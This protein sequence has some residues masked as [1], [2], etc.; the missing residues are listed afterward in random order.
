MIA[1]LST[2]KTTPENFVELLKTDEESFPIHKSVKG[3]V[4][5]KFFTD[6]EK[7]MFAYVSVWE[8]RK[9]LDDY[10][11]ARDKIYP[12][13][14]EKARELVAEPPFAHIYEV[15]EPKTE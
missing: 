5:V 6:V 8:T 15:Y 14:R 2:Y 3:C 4:D 11:E 1:V 7:N 13:V 12:N 10:H 9:D